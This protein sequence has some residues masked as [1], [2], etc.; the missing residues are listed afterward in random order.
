MKPLIEPLGQRAGEFL[1]Q[2]VAS[3]HYAV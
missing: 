3:A 2:A 1:A